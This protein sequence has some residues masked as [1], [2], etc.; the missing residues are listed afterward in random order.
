M[1]GIWAA[2]CAISAIIVYFYIPETRMVPMEELGAL[3]G[4]EVI[5]H[6]T[7]DGQE[8]VDSDKATIKMF[9]EGHHEEIENAIHEK[10]AT[11]NGSNTSVN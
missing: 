4:D 1:Y 5:V 7:A 6:L 8:I 10:V 3:F 2:L 9:I 11:V